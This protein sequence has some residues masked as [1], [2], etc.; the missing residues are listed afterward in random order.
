MFPT[1]YCHV[2]S[3]FFKYVQTLLLLSW[4]TIGKTLPSK[5]LSNHFDRLIYFS[6]IFMSSFIFG[7]FYNIKFVLNLESRRYLYWYYDLNDFIPWQLW[8]YSWFN[9]IA[10]LCELK[11]PASNEENNFLGLIGTW[12]WRSCN[13]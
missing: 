12:D 7:L 10:L 5:T 3:F 1:K 2:S 13:L 8:F 4:I 11:K 6:D 9:Y